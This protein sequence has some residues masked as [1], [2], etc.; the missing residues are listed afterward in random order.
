MSA[1]SLGFVVAR[2]LAMF[3]LATSAYYC[4]AALLSLIWPGVRLADW[5][6]P[7]PFFLDGLVRFVFAGILWR[8]ADSFG[9]GSRD[10]APS[11]PIDA[12]SALRIVAVGLCVY[13]A[14]SNLNHVVDF[15]V[16]L[17]NPDYRAE[18]VPAKA[19]Y[20]TFGDLVTFVVALVALPFVSKGFS[21][22]RAI[23]Y[24][25]L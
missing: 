13:F 17:T 1:R 19:A 11:V 2:A 20:Y 22:K 25:R 9:G 18:F 6:Y 4:G 23:A 5:L 14:F 7:A 21:L 16:S 15:I 8:G 12:D 10:T 3:L 24:P